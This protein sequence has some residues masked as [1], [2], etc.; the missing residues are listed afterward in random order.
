[1][2]EIPRGVGA[3]F[4]GWGVPEGG[5]K[6]LVLVMGTG[7]NHYMKGREEGRNSRNPLTGK[8]GKLYGQGNVFP[9]EKL[10]RR[11]RRG[12]SPRGRRPS[13]FVRTQRRGFL[14]RKIE[15]PQNRQWL[16]LAQ[17]KKDLRLGFV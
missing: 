12:D 8:G 11:G 2:R 15:T 7:G 16:D 3:T 14:C 5:R 9:K 10:L 13:K 17:K 6:S 4:T 1:M